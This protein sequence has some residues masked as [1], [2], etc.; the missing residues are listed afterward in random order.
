MSGQQVEMN[1]P[2]GH[3]SLLPD[4]SASV[5]LRI[6]RR[7]RAATLD[8]ID[9]LS[10]LDSNRFWLCADCRQE[11]DGLRMTYANPQAAT[12][13]P[14]KQ[15][16]PLWRQE[17]AVAVS[18]VLA[19]AR[20]LF[21]L[22][23]E[24]G[25]GQSLSFSLS[26]VQV[27]VAGNEARKER[28]LVMPLPM[29]GATFADFIRADEDCWAWLSA[30]ELLGA[31]PR[32][33]AYLIGA[34]LF[35]CLVANL[36]PEEMSRSER[37]RRLLLYRGGNE[38]LTRTAMASA[39]PKCQSA[40]SGK[41]A[42]FIMG[43]LAPRLGR[44]LTTAE[45]SHRLDQFCAELSLHNL[46]CHWE[47][48]AAEQRSSSHVG[49]ARR[50]IET[51]VATAPDHEVPWDAVERLRA[52]DGDAAGAASAA[53]RQTSPP[54]PG[55]FIGYVRSLINGGDE[56]R[57]ELARL[58][59]T[60]G[61]NRAAAG[62]EGNLEP[63]GSIQEAR[64]STDKLSE[65][66]YIYL[67]YAQ[68]RWLTEPGQAL[69]H[70]K[71]DFTISWN[72]VVRCIV[73]GRL[74]AEQADWIT[75]AACC[76]EG[77]RVLKEMSHTGG[78]R[79]R[80]AAAYF[81]LLDG[82]AHVCAVSQKGLGHDYLSDA[83]TRLESAWVTS[84]QAEVTDMEDSIVA[85][86]RWLNDLAR[87]DQRLTMLCLGVE[88]FIQSLGPCGKGLRSTSGPPPVPWFDEARLFSC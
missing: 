19:L 42:D 71:R 6:G 14:L 63:S 49:R 61:E 5:L 2:T 28:Y 24:L 86:L 44:T 74:N 65:E 53:A 1:L 20:Q 47:V 38:N 17:P 67:A 60:L 56:Q 81:D 45:A 48:G 31:V 57:Q 41:L 18:R 83:F 77:R 23:D 82:I 79:G 9:S 7:N 32:D 29:G 36:F 50:I 25:R 22:A 68:G 34:I 58:T 12:V 21:S 51:L 62:G 70:L 54:H 3:L 40:T 35:Y 33:R 8:E 72:K 78:V 88:A 69:V 64:V 39:L 52:K 80:Y 84:Q 26:P 16:A 46:A 30:D 13:T 11:A 55:T 66:E 10:T 73:A 43:L 15:L 37:V 75:A 76:R 4:G 27:F 59:G 85:W 87:R